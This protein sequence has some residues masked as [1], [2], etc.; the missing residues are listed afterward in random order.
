MAVPP[1]ALPDTGLSAGCRGFAPGGRER[2]ELTVAEAA[3]RAGLGNAVVEDLENGNVGQQHDRIATPRS[4]R[5]HADSLGV[6]GS[7]YVL[8]A[9]EQWPPSARADHQ[10]RNRCGLSNAVLSGWRP[11]T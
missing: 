3:V 11:T 4:L 1:T 2:A 9:V 6:P 5:S 8:V 7:D 10:L